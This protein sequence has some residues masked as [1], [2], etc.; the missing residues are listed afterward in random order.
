MAKRR[1][2][3]RLDLRTKEGK[4]AEQISNFLG[5]PMG[6]CLLRLILIVAALL[7]LGEIF[8]SFGEWLG[9]LE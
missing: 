2:D 9:S 5:T 3:G 8:P 7:I 1:K 6:G 4:N